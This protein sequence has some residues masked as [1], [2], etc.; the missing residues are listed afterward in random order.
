MNPIHNFNLTPNLWLSKNEKEV[1]GLFKKT[2]KKLMKEKREIV[3][4]YIEKKVSNPLLDMTGIAK[5]YL[6]TKNNFDKLKDKFV[7]ES[8]IENSWLEKNLFEEMKNLKDSL[9]NVETK[10]GLENIRQQFIEWW[11]NINEASFVSTETNNDIDNKE[12]TDNNQQT[13]YWQNITESKS[14][15]T[16]EIVSFE[17]EK[18]EITETQ[19]KYID[20]IAKKFNNPQ[21]KN[22]QKYWPIV[23]HEALKHPETKDIIPKIFAQINKESGRKTDALNNKWE[24]SVG[25]MQINKNAGH[26]WKINWKHFDIDKVEWN[27]AYGIH[28]LANCIKEA[29]WNIRKWFNIYNWKWNFK[30]PE[31]QQYAH[32]II[33]DKTFNGNLVA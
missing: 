26:T 30:R 33:N 28:F 16:S 5:D 2:K 22:I 15:N 9:E 32:S 12:Q 29:G 7:H 19:Q 11:I 1:L 14:W 18:I 4:E 3:E 6:I 23:I 13:T 17:W 31:T 24:Y 8:I 10:Q 25:L 27:I 20:K 21:K